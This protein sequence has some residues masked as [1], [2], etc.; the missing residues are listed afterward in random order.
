MSQT[1]TA[2]FVFFHSSRRVVCAWNGL[3]RI[4][5]LAEEHGCRRPALVVDAFFASGDIAARAA[6]ALAK[7]TGT[8][9]PVVP[10]PAHEPDTDSIAAAAA[11]LVEAK[12]D[13]IVAI[14]GGSAM[15]TAK[16][17]R[18][19]LSNPGPVEAVSGFGKKLLPHAS[20]FV[21]VPTTAGTGSEVS[22]SAI[23]SKSGSDVKLIFRSQEMTPQIALLDAS[24]TTSCPAKVTAQSGYDALTH[25]VEA[26]VSKMANA[27]TDPFALESMR[28]LAASLVR[29]YRVPD[30]RE[31]RTQCLIASCQAAVAFNSAN[32]GLAHAFAAPLGALHHVAH[33]LGNALALPVVTAFNQ[34]TLG[35]KGETIAAIFGTRDAATAMSKVRH[36]LDLDLSLDRFVPDDPAR[37]KVAQA[38]S[39]SGQVRMNPRLADIDDLRAMLE[40]MRKPTGGQTP[41]FAR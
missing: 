11:A 30:D 10:V 2:E 41:A 3:D 21:C 9:P 19:L 38:A 16:V 25:A 6:D 14:G 36:E 5:A 4:G 18:M 20:L 17:A 24:L 35:R 12:P 1:A 32:L 22:E 34:P 33:G 28:L 15:D 7:A 29:A 26:Y 23:A 40:A 8:R 27:M 31:A 13:M 39:R 37:E